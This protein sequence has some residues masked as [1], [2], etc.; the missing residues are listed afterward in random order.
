VQ[1]AI[2]RNSFTLAAVFAAALLTACGSDHK[3][4]TSPPVAAS[5]VVSSANGSMPAAGTMQFSAVVKDA[6]GNTID[7]TPTWSVVNGGGTISTSGL[8]TAGD[9][10]GTYVNTI[11]AAVGSVSSTGS[12]T[13]NAGELASITISPDTAS[14]AVGATHQFTAVGKDSHGNVITFSPT[15]TVTAGGTIDT[16]GLFTAGTTAG[17]FAQMI[18]AT[19]GSIADSASV[20]VLPGELA[21]ITLTPSPKT[22]AIGDT[23]Q[24]TAVGKDAN[25]NIV[26]ITPE[27]TVAA[28]GGTISNTGLFTAGTVAGEFANTVTATSGSVSGTATIVVSPGAL[29]LLTVTP[30]SQSLAIHAT[31]QFSVVGTDANGNV[32]SIDP[33]WQ[34]VGGG[35]T[36]NSATG[37]FTAGGTLGTFTNTIVVTSGVIAATASV[38]VTAGPL[39]TITVSPSSPFVHEGFNQTFTAVGKDADGHVLS[40]TPVWSIAS[41]SSNA[42]TINS[43]SGSFHASTHSGSYHNAIVATVGSIK[44]NASVTVYNH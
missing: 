16:A 21:S 7:L 2:N 14:L 34:V 25:N 10:A 30:P 41:G 4:V 1:I 9:S 38:T 26:A 20:T 35:G 13:I 15:W 37:L 39:A 23:A 42:G 12:V 43:S 33:V 40:I 29:A 8:F 24:F 44:G 17:A 27:W 11:K 19:N 22:L 6:D 31:Q 32:V 3:D 36:I 5:I 18:V 28:N